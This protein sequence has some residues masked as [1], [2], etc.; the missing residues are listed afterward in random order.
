MSSVSMALNGIGKTIDGQES[1]PDS[2]NTWLKN[3]GGYASGDLFVWG[4]V[5]SLGLAI[6]SSGASR[7][8]V[9]SYF[10]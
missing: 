6:V 2:L 3:H 10:D 5:S 1:N 8:S 7:S 4:S 9:V